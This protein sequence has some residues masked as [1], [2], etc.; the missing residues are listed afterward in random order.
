VPRPAAG[1]RPRARRGLFMA[2]RDEFR[3]CARAL[4]RNAVLNSAHEPSPRVVI[5][6]QHRRGTQSR[7][8]RC[9]RASYAGFST[10]GVVNPARDGDAHFACG[11]VPPGPAAGPRASGPARPFHSRAGRFSAAHA[12]ASTE[13]GAELRTRT[14]S[15]RRNPGS[16][17]PG[18]S[19]P[20]VM[21]AQ[22]S[23][24]ELCPPPARR[25]RAHRRRGADRVSVRRRAGQGRR[26]IPGRPASRQPLARHPFSRRCGTRAAVRRP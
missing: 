9:C 14:R 2:A 17:P 20:H 12:G 26:A 1:S 4:Q 22:T 15:T 23:R 13:G 10:A 18:Y 24:A 11:V 21:A 8:R 19:T 7:T 6:V 25:P 16:A 3:R 5:R